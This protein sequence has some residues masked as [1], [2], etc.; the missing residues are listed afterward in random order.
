MNRINLEQSILA[1]IIYEPQM[2]DV[3]KSKIKKSAFNIY[4]DEYTAILALEQENMPID[5][6][7]ILKKGGREEAIVN[8]M[9][10]TPIADLESYVDELKNIYKD[11]MIKLLGRSLN[12][13]IEIDDKIK[14][15][16]KFI[17]FMDA[18]VDF[19]DE[20]SGDD[21]LSLSIEHKTRIST[22]IE[23]IDSAYDGG[24]STGVLIYVTGVEESGKTHITN[25][26]IENMSN[27]VK[28]GIVSI[29]FG[30]AE[31]KTRLQKMQYNKQEIIPANI[32]SI[33]GDI[34]IST[35]ESTLRRWKKSGVSVVVIDSLGMI[36]NTNGFTKQERLE[37]TGTRLFRLA[38]ELDMVFLVITTSTK[39][40]HKNKLPSIYGS[41]Q[42]N[43][44]CHS[45][46]HILRD[47]DSGKRM[48]WINKNKQTYKY[49]KIEL[50]FFDNGAIAHPSKN[51]YSTKDEMEH[52]P[53]LS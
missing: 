37:D 53:I 9:S 49:P 11:D 3:V 47:L 19:V 46:W 23:G 16:N 22:G 27:L 17:A 33:F 25:K 10:A 1:T 26:I 28:V 32:K 18:Q 20:Y 29:E 38:Q 39:E 12:D 13:D 40:D 35:L 21:I 5:E 48:L 42:L 31:Y 30:V 24:L 8:I 44:Y 4:K 45:K 6:N 41:Q 50:K 15:I 36:T 51:V 2:L 43:H 52:V 7:F 14:K 34:D